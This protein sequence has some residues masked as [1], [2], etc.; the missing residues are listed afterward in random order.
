MNYILT[1][2]NYIKEDWA[3]STTELS[4]R[5]GDR[6]LMDM[7]YQ[8]AWPLL[9]SYAIPE[10]WLIKDPGFPIL[11]RDN[12]NLSTLPPWCIPSALGLG[13]NHHNSRLGYRFVPN[14][15]A[16]RNEKILV[17]IHSS[18][19]PTWAKII[20]TYGPEELINW[21]WGGRT[22]E[23]PPSWPKDKMVNFVH[24][25][26]SGDLSPPGRLVDLSFGNQDTFNLFH[27]FCLI[28][29]SALNTKNL[30]L[31]GKVAEMRKTFF[32]DWQILKLE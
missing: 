14:N 22:N 17:L 15:F 19:V 25:L 10:R 2:D 6:S 32:G 31:D 28:N 8:S 13:K 24:Y 30:F 4:E 3:L 23:Q 20:E 7:H 27:M 9:H 5:Q 16:Y 26:L 18:E 21:C 11:L 12:Q 1:G 29:G